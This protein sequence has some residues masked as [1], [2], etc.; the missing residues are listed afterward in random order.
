VFAD[1]DDMVLGR[2]VRGHT[3]PHLAFSVGP[4]FCLGARLARTEGRLA[5][6]RLLPRM[7]NLSPATNRNPERSA[8]PLL[9]GFTRLD[10]VFGDAHDDL[11]HRPPLGQFG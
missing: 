3:K 7:T 2:R 4:H 5:L 8:N 11:S 9:R 6:Q 10:L 1:A